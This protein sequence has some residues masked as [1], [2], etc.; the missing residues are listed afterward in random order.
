MNQAQFD[1]DNANESPA[2]PCTR[3]D[4]WHDFRGNPV[5]KHFEG[6]AYTWERSSIESDTGATIDN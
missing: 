3:N 1:A 6:Q 5:R 2:A 4:W